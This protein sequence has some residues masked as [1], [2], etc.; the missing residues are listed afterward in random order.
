MSLEEF[1]AQVEFA[2]ADTVR[3]CGGEPTLHPDFTAMLDFALELPGVA[4]F[5][6]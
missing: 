3:F 1:T 6:E 5:R 4:R 2:G